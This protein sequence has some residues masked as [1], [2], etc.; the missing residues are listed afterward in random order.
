[1]GIGRPFIY[2]FSAYGTEGV[3]RALQILKVSPSPL[4]KCLINLVS[5]D[6]FE[7]NLRLLG[8]PTLKDIV[9]SMVDTSNIHA[10]IVSVPGDNLYNNNC[11]PLSSRITHNH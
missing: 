11:K 2:A 8:A 5:Q 4:Q 6:E 1:M 10:H 9:P 7:M 3:D